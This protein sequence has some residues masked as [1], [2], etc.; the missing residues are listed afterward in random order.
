M[1]LLREFDYWVAHLGHPIF[2]L[3]LGSVKLLTLSQY[4]LFWGCP[5]GHPQFYVFHI[6]VAQSGDPILTCFMLGVANL[7]PPIYSNPAIS[8]GLMPGLIGVIGSDDSSFTWVYVRVG[9]SAHPKCTYLDRAKLPYPNTT[10]SF[11]FAGRRIGASPEAPLSLRVLR[12][13]R[14]IGRLQI[15]LF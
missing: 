6:G 11:G 7:P 14:L 3:N 15:R 10:L 5:F 2:S 9:E 1:C 4:D 13:G 8:P 12:W